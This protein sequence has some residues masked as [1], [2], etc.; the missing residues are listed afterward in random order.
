MANRSGRH[1]RA[2]VCLL[3]AA[4]ALGLTGIASAQRA[5]REYVAAPKVFKVVA[6]DDQN[7]SVLVQAVLKPGQRTPFVSAPARVIYWLTPCQY[8]TV[9]RNGQTTKSIVRGAEAVSLNAVEAI[10]YENIGKATCSMLSFEPKDDSASAKTPVYP[11]EVPRCY[12]A[13]PSHCKV[14]ASNEA[15]VLVE[16]DLKAGQQTEFFSSPPM[17]EYFLTDCAGRGIFKGGAGL[18]FPMRPAGWAYGE[19]RLREYAAVKNIGTSECRI[20]YFMPK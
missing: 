8:R 12:L 5:P 19:P 10:S 14:I 11:Q 18:D 7:Q 4:I 9:A 16:L 2:V 1:H 17:L 6:D 15:W 13:S 3:G 20:L